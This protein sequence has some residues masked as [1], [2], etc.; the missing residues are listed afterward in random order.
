[1][2]GE[3]VQLLKNHIK[4][5]LKKKYS[6][7][8]IEHALVSAGFD[9]NSVNTALVEMGLKKPGFWESIHSAKKTV[10]EKPEV[11]QEQPEKKEVPLEPPPKPRPFAPKKQESFLSGLFKPKPAEKKEMRI[12]LPPKPAEKK[13]KQPEL[14]KQESFLSGLFKPKPAE[15]KEMRI[16]LPPKPA[17][18]KEMPPEP[19]KPVRE[20]QP[21]KVSII[22]IIAAI[23]ITMAIFGGVLLLFSPAGC[24]T[25][26]CFLAKAN[27]CEKATYQNVIAGAQINYES[28]T[29]CTIVKT[30][31]KVAGTEPA[32]IKSKF[33]GKSMV[34]AYY[35]GDFSPMHVETIS[36]LIVNCE[37][38]L[39]QELIKYVI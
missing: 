6:P 11:L 39:K 36:G 37:G 21:K 25:K 31:A 32:E 12:E 3:T 5:E 4:K 15:K 30:L 1:M 28:R 9:K 8:E 16:E 18:K 34:C 26:E 29:D 19:K 17:E 38:P 20:Y 7:K 14:K 13:Q 22:K 24:A 33:E 23:I 35:K 10:E 27:A 2:A